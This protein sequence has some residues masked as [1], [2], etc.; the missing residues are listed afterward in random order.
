MIGSALPIYKDNPNHK[1]VFLTAQKFDEKEA[2]KMKNKF[3]A[4]LIAEKLEHE[5]MLEKQRSSKH[6][7]KIVAQE[8]DI[9]SISIIKDLDLNDK[10]KMFKLA[11]QWWAFN[12]SPSYWINEANVWADYSQSIK[13]NFFKR[14]IQLGHVKKDS[15]R[16]KFFAAYEDV[17]YKYNLPRAL[18]LAEDN[19]GETNTLI[20][21][22]C[23]YCTD[24]EGKKCKSSNKGNLAAF[25]FKKSQPCYRTDYDKINMA[26]VEMYSDLA[27]EFNEARK[28]GVSNEDYVKMMDRE[29][30]A[31]LRYGDDR[32]Y[33]KQII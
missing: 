3:N 33:I 4:K 12:T 16:L 13:N 8:I 23:K 18:A 15:S 6:V 32:S 31:L 29:H 21:G 27:A 14:L 20:Q 24:N 25:P 26:N 10:E 1:R 7:Q 22:A 19:D 30:R 11:A 28:N 2:L 17:I 5:K 9:M